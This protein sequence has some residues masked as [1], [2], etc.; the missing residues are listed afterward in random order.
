M[1]YIKYYYD[2]IVTFTLFFI[3]HR[4]SCFIVNF[5]TLIQK[6]TKVRTK[7]LPFRVLVLSTYPTNTEG[8]A[9]MES[10]I[11]ECSAFLLLLL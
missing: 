9:A 3:F 7:N 5:F 4:N 2:H 1:R 8:T 11:M 6:Q 10:F